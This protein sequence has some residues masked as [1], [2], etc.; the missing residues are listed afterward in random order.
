MAPVRRRVQPYLNLL[1]PGSELILGDDD[2]S[3]SH[4]RRG[5]KD[6]PFESLSVGT[7][8][9]LAVLTRLAFADLLREQGHSTA[10]V[11]DDA[12]VYA[13]D[14]RFE[15]MLYALRRAAQ[16]QQI[17]VLTC[18]ERDYVSAGFPVIRLSTCRAASPA[19]IARA[20]V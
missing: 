11:L 18:R 2:L 15:S 10:V 9:Q 5:G 17:L 4:L 7:R 12:L 16:H 6:E 20:A 14:Q 13:D 19:G 1:M 3:I 8:E